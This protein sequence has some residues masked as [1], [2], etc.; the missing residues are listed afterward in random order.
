[1]TLAVLLVA[2]LGVALV[3]LDDSTARAHEQAVDAATRELTED[4]RVL[5]SSL[6]GPARDGEQAA[7]AL[8]TLTAEAITGSTLRD[9][10]ERDDVRAELDEATGQLLAAADDL[11]AAAAEDHPTRPS[12]LP[13]SDVDR[14][15]DRLDAVDDQ[16]RTTADALRRAADGPGALAADAADLHAAATTYAATTDDV[17]GD[18]DPDEVAAAWD[19]ER[20]RLADYRAAIDAAATHDALTD[21]AAIHDELVTPLEQ[22]ADRAVDLLDEDDVDGYEDL[23]AEELPEVDTEELADRLHDAVQAAVAVAIEDAEVAEERALALLREVEN[24]RR[25]APGRPT[26]A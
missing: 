11:D 2:G 8:R 26:T 17:E 21:L 22:V 14:L 25:D 15:Y 9:G 20:D 23:R 16:A 18:T 13:V 3:Q 24:L 7:T 19:A 6:A 4:V 5:R 12:A 10:I 1:V